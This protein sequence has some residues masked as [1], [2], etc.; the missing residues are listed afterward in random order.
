MR[1]TAEAGGEGPEA[2]TFPPTGRAGRKGKFTRAEKD[3]I[4][5]ELE[6]SG[7]SVPDFAKKRGLSGPTV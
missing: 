7:E 4:L 2:G 6:A 5:A 1:R 3:A